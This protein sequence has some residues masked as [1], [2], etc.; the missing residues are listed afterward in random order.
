MLSPKKTNL[1]D[2]KNTYSLRSKGWKSIKNIEVKQ[3]DIVTLT[4]GRLQIY[5]DEILKITPC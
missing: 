3:A 2:K 1:S 4:F 5:S